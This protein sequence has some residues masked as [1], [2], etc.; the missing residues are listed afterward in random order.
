MDPDEQEEPAAESG[1]LQSLTRLAA[2]VTVL[3]E[4]AAMVWVMVPDHRKRELAMRAAAA[5]RRVTAT[6]ASRTARAAMARELASGADDY[7]VPYWFS[8]ARDACARAYERLRY[9]S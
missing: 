4:L 7:Q 2:L 8:R 1:T 5:G 6:L 9:T 3:V